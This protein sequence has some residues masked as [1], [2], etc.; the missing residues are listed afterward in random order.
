MICEIYN[1][2]QKIL[3]SRKAT[4]FCAGNQAYD[5]ALSQIWK[6]P[7][8]IYVQ[9]RHVYGCIVVIADSEFAARTMMSDDYNYDKDREIEEFEIREGFHYANLGDS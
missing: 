3:R 5:R 4:M 6:S 9:D 8:K 7:L 1:L 2:Y